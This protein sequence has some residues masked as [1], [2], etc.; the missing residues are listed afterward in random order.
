[1]ER[2]TTDNPESNF[3]RIMNMVYGKDGWGYIRY[4]PR[5]EDPDM[6]ITDFCAM[7]CKHRECEDA[8]IIATSDDTVKDELLFE[9]NFEN[10]PVA[11]IYAALCGFCHVR[12]RLKLYE[13][14]GMMPPESK[15]KDE[16]ILSEDDPDFYL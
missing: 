5:D 4:A 14:A 16:H 12:S 2:M 13:D 10:C 6:K 15:K 11:S 1:M 9:C 7:L 8:D 3:S